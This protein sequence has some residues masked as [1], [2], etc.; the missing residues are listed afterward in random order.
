MIVKGQVTKYVDL[1]SACHAKQL[2]SAKAIR[3]VLFFNLTCRFF[4]KSCVG[5]PRLLSDCVVLIYKGE[6]RELHQ[7]FLA[8]NG[9][10][11]Y[12]NAGAYLKRCAVLTFL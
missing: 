4:V 3:H 7:S 9:F 11:A 5:I 8:Q 6:H 10:H 12:K 2:A 1:V